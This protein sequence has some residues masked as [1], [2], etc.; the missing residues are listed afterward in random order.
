MLY[1]DPTAS[2]PWHCSTAL[3]VQGLGAATLNEFKRHKTAQ[4]P[5]PV[6]PI[7]GDSPEETPTFTTRLDTLSGKKGRGLLGPPKISTAE[8]RGQREYQARRGW[9]A[10]HVYLPLPKYI[11]MY[12]YIYILHGRFGICTN[13]QSDRC[14]KCATCVEYSLP[15][16]LWKEVALCSR[17][18]S[19]LVALFCRMLITV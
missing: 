13:R 15:R 18:T 4:P 3:S 7:V 5:T 12:I 17:G 10:T 1:H 8:S 19:T 11:S 6:T 14:A 9:P 2:P 16:P